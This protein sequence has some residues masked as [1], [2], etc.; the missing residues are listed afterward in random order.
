M[1]QK[2]AGMSPVQYRHH[3]N[4]LATLILFSSPYCLHL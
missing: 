2:L 1:N 3:T 4:Q